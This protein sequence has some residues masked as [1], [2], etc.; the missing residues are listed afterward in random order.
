M[1]DSRPSID[2]WLAETKGT[3]KAEGVGMYLVHNGVV[4]G[5]SRDGTP[6]TGMELIVD[7]ARLAE[8]LDTA[9]LMEGVEHVRAWVNEGKLRVGDDIMYV[10]VSGDIRE[11]VVEALLALVKMIK[12][13]VV[14][15]VELRD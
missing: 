15:E 12:T 10:L 1:Q 14:T 2:R 13:E 7:R 11:N 4:R 3:G 8:V 5:H 6:V 9:R